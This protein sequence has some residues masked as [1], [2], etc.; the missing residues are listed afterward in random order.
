MNPYVIVAVV[1]AADLISLPFIIRWIINKNS[2]T[3]K[4]VKWISAAVL[5][6]VVIDVVFSYAIISSS[7]SYDRTGKRYSYNETITY[8]TSDGKEFYYEE[9]TRDR[10]HYV[11]KD[12][13]EI[14]I[15]DRVY[16]DKDGY[17][18]YDK[19][20]ELTSNEGNDVYVDKDGNK[21]YRAD[22]IEWNKNGDICI[23]KSGDLQ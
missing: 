15:A 6:S 19:N 17:L 4:R 8:Y 5:I 12:G 11:S 21:Y 20:N 18:Y 14:Y 2:K 1:I 9:S 10:S 7:Y 22:K 13:T 16:V 23:K 3:N